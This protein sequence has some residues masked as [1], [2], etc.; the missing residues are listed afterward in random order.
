MLHMSHNDI[1]ISNV[2][3]IYPGMEYLLYVAL[4][5]RPVHLGKLAH[6]CFIA[7]LLTYSNRI[8]KAGEVKGHQFFSIT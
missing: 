4:L 5:L 1:T 7:M 2:S 6:C 8:Y 3:T